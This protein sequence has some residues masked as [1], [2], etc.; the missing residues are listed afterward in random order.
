MREMTHASDTGS[1]HT[2]EQHGQVICCLKMQQLPTN[3]VV[4][5]FTH[6]YTLASRNSAVNLTTAAEN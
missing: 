5:A 1:N 6:F 3:T 2:L 4:A